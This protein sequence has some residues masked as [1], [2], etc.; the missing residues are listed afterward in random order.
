MNLC[1]T[2]LLNV[3]SVLMSIAL[4]SDC[5]EYLPQLHE[6]AYA[7]IACAIIYVVAFAVG[8]GEFH[9]SL[10]FCLVYGML[11]KGSVVSTRFY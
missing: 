2:N 7:A 9:S 4:L 10:S 8:L 1:F 11:T 5:Q 3:S 6:V